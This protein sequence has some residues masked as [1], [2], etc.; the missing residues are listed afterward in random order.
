MQVLFHAE[1]NVDEVNSTLFCTD[2]TNMNQ[3]LTTRNF[4]DSS[5]I[6]LYAANSDIVI[7][8]CLYSSV[9]CQ[10]SVDFSKISQNIWSLLSLN[11]E[12][13]VG[14][15]VVNYSVIDSEYLKDP[16][17]SMISS[18]SGVFAQYMN[19]NVYIAQCPTN[20]SRI[21]FIIYSMPMPMPMPMAEIKK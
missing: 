8:K 2:Q 18:A 20:P 10:K 6:N 16:N 19:K 3:E 1:I 4:Y 7:G 17:V 11:Y 9:D 14:T 5:E 13:A 12:G 15:F 21:M